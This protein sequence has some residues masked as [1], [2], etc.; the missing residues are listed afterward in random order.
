M[1]ASAVDPTIPKPTPTVIAYN[2]DDLTRAAVVYIR[3]WRAIRRPAQQTGCLRAASNRRLHADDQQRP[4]QRQL[5]S[6]MQPDGTLNPSAEPVELPDPSDSGPSYW[7]ALGIWAYGEGYAAFKDVD[8]GFAAFLRDRM[9][10]AVDA[11]ERQVLDDYGQP[12]MVDGL[13]LPAWL[14][15]DGADASAEAVLGLSAYV[16]ST[17]CW[18][19]RRSSTWCSTAT[20]GGRH[21][22]GAGRVNPPP[23]CS[24]SGTRSPSSPIRTIGEACWQRRPL[25]RGIRLSFQCGREASHTCT[26]IEGQHAALV[27]G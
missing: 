8:P 11:L 26:L 7:L 9:E 23:G 6:V 16:N 22:C 3:H 5:R 17:P 1:C 10:L 27:S 24:S 2:T 4:T 21:F 15:A 18:F 19:N 25:E 12:Q 20:T 13:A 14:I